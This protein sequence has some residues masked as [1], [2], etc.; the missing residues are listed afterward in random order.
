MYA[1]MGATGNIGSKLVNVLLDKD[2]KIT[3][4]GRSSRATTIVS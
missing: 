2:D 1:I 4:V 3:V